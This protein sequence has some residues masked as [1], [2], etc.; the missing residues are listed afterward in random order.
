MNIKGL[1]SL[2]KRRD[3][4]D[5][6][7]YD[8]KIRGEY[9]DNTTFKLKGVDFSFPNTPLFQ[10]GDAIEFTVRVDINNDITP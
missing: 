4:N 9:L 10:S 8:Y 7:H 1:P 2:M 3:K 5:S 6:F